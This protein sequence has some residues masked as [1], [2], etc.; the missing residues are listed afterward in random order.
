M[1][2]VF[3]F[4]VPENLAKEIDKIAVQI[5]RPKSYVIRKALENYAHEYKD[6]QV[7]MKRLADKDDEIITLNEM[8]KKFGV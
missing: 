2:S 5:D 1:S 4:R 6:Y 3:N 7:A 8:R